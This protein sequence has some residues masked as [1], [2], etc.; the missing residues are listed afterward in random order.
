MAFLFCLPIKL[1]RLFKELFT[2]IVSHD[3]YEA[4]NNAALACLQSDKGKWKEVG[5]EEEGENYRGPLNATW[6][7]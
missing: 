5:D 3:R 1:N 6:S 4:D 7:Q 2:L